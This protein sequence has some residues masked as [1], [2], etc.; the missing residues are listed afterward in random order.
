MNDITPPTIIAFASPKGGAGKSTSCLSIAGA[1][2]KK[3]YSVHI[4]DFDQSQALWRWYT[5]TAAPEAKTNLTAQLPPKEDLPAFIQSLW[6]HP[7]D[8]LLLDL[9]GLLTRDM[10]HVA[11]F[12]TLTI[13]PLKLSELDIV[14][15]NRLHDQLRDIQTRVHK[16]IIHRLLVND[17]QPLP[18]AYEYALLDELIQAQ[19]PRFTTLIRHR[20]AYKEI[21]GTGLTPHFADRTQP[22]I[23]KAVDELDHLMAEIE[24]LL[25][26]DQSA[27]QP[28]TK[29]AA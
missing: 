12:A 11:A 6:R 24:A 7:A 3:G 8:V 26:D 28:P 27:I 14:E 9:P 13:T 22:K 16:P 21:F 10:L 4:V 15:A 20:V 29:E 5:T 17:V 25:A 18:G 1:L 23:S 2:L 19:L